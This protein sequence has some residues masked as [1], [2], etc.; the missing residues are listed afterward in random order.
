MKLL[1]NQVFLLYMLHG[2][3]FKVFECICIAYGVHLG[4]TSI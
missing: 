4:A 3:V 2:F 1:V